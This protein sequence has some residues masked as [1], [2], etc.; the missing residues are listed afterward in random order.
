MPL[1]SVI[2][3][4]FNRAN[5]LNKAIQS[6]LNQN[7]ENWELIIVDDGSEDHTKKLVKSY[8]SDKRISYYFQ[9]NKGVSA[10]R[11]YGATNSKGEWLVFL[12]S[13]DELEEVAL[14]SFANAISANF[15]V[16]VGGIKIISE[17]TI[18]TI[19]PKNVKYL[20]K[21]P[22]IFCLKKSTFDA[23]KGYDEALHFGEN[24]ELF[25]RIRL[26]SKEEIHL[27]VITVKYHKNPQGGS[28]N[29]RNM[30][31]SNL[32]ILN[33]HRNTLSKN[34]KHIYHQIVGV[35]QMRFGNYQ[36]ARKH[37]W[38]AFMYKP[39]KVITLIRFILSLTPSVA[40]F[41]YTQEVKN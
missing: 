19:L 2:I 27:N 28:K 5:L 9:K 33:K 11:N 3:P 6:V 13:D 25:H 18:N 17:N 15:H 39:T 35:N 38:M 8:L 23:V 7:F 22:G 24:T 34:M 32:H 36:E 41:F 1:I 40:S 10:A 30:T 31:D 20:A 4:T 37:L 26:I 29:L 21:I 12:D 16:I 14:F